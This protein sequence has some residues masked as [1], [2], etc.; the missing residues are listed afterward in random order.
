MTGNFS[1]APLEV[2]DEEQVGGVVEVEQ[3]LHGGVPAGG[4]A[5]LERFRPVRLGAEYAAL[6]DELLNAEP[7]ASAVSSADC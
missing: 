3:P 7:G 1:G 4:R 2:A 6:Y 5:A